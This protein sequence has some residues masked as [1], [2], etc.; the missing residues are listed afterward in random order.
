LEQALTKGELPPPT[1]APKA[2]V[3]QL[4]EQI[5]Q[6]KI[7]A[8][9]AKAQVNKLK[10]QLAQQPDAEDLQQQLNVAEAK[11]Q[12]EEAKLEQLTNSQEN[13]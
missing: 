8:A 12:E 7:A 6:Q 5:K 1:A 3:N 13:R 11:Q 4:A 10:K 2:E 9:L